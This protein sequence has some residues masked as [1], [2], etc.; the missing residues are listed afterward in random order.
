[1][2]KIVGASD[3]F[4]QCWIKK[5]TEFCFEWICTLCLHP[6]A[7]QSQGVAGQLT[8][9]ARYGATAE[10]H[11]NAGVGCVFGVAGQPEVLQA[12]E[13]TGKCVWEKEALGIIYKINTWYV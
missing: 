5:L 3:T 6:G 11:Q 13:R 2:E 4:Q 12:L 1:M 9:G 7:D 8:A 10:Q